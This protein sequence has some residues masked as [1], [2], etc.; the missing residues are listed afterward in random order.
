[1][2]V[3]VCV[4]GLVFLFVLHLPCY[5]DVHSH[6]VSPADKPHNPMVNAGAIV[7]TSLI[8]VSCRYHLI[9]SE[10]NF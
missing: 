1:M 5:A 8:K 6:P 7:C 10:A 3:C 4:G 9:K 2:C